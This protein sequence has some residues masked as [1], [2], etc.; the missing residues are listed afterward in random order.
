MMDTRALAEAGMR[1]IAGIDMQVRTILAHYITRKRR[2]HDAHHA[3][4]ARVR[5]ESQM[6]EVDAD[7]RNARHANHAR[8]MQHRAIAN[9]LDGDIAEPSFG[10]VLDHLHAVPCAPVVGRKGGGKRQRIPVKEDFALFDDMPISCSVYHVTHTEH[11]ELYDAEIIYVNRRFS[12]LG[13][14]AEEA[15]LGHHVRE[16]Y[17][18]IG[19]EWF[20]Y[21]KRAALDGETVENEYADPLSGQK[22]QL[23]IWQVVCPGYCAATY[24]ET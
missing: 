6:P 24:R 10:I 2:V 8:G 23:K 4:V 20:E 15:V 21:A 22:F 9:R 18:Y 16:M 3:I 12:Q 17:P 5:K 7:D 13:E 19:E 14:I 1:Q 11:S